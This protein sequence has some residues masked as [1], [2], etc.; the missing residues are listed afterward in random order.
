MRVMENEFAL[1]YY[2]SIRM[3]MIYSTNGIYIYNIP[4]VV[5]CQCITV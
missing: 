2:L 1:T 3:T 4:F 5:V